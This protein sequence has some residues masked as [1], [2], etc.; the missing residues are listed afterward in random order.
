[1][2]GRDRCSRSSMDKTTRERI[3]GYRDGINKVDNNMEDGRRQ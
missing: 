3:E 1:M 2:N